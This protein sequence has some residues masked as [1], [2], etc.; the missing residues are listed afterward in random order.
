MKDVILEDY[1]FEKESIEFHC[2]EIINTIR[3]HSDL[4]FKTES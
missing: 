1:L 2:D 4:V 3:L